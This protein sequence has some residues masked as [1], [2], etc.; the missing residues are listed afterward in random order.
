MVASAALRSTTMTNSSSSLRLVRR[1]N[2]SSAVVNQSC[3]PTPSR[4]ST[5]R[6]LHQNS[7]SP[8]RSSTHLRNPT[9]NLTLPSAILSRNLSFTSSKP[10]SSSAEPQKPQDSANQALAEISDSASQERSEQIK[11]NLTSIEAEGVDKAVSEVGQTVASTAG[12]IKE[13][14]S[15]V[16]QDAL[17]SASVPSTSDASSLIG[18]IEPTI[19]SNLGEALT[20]SAI[21]QYGE[22][23]ALGL[24]HWHGPVGLLTDLL[25]NVGYY[26]GLPWWGTIMATTLVLRLLISP[27]TVRGQKNNIRLSNI[28]PEMKKGMEDIKHYKA[29]GNQMEM[30]NAVM[31]VQ[32]L[33]KDNNCSPFGA[34]TPLFIQLPVMFSFFWSLEKIAKSGIESFKVGGPSWT[35]DLS[36]PDPTYVLPIVST[37]ATI[38]VAE[39]GQKLGTQNPGSD[40]NQAKMI[41]YILRAVL[42]LA[43]WFTSTFP[44]GVLIYWATTNVYSLVQLVV[45]QIPSVRRALHFPERLSKP[46][47]KYDPNPPKSLSDRFAEFKRKFSDSAPPSSSSSSNLTE[48]EIQRLKLEFRNRSRSSGRHEEDAARVEALGKLIGGGGRVDETL[49]RADPTASQPSPPPPSANPSQGNRTHTATRQTAAEIRN[50]RVQAARERKS[51]GRR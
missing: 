51:S 37:A 24:A 2:P 16:A 17:S 33:M 3:R 28:Q 35:P 13:E 23:K 12:S 11:E 26:T 9:I 44:S 36:I 30:Q 46:I 25:E 7:L 48:S 8:I 14:A 49:L 31:R 41:K 47:N 34:L 45:L 6:N 1:L 22:L 39:M 29:V 40:P 18:N 10:A 43:G 15:K 21:V 27:F 50:K 4:Q 5:F 32:K 19:A 38:A 42:P 20:P